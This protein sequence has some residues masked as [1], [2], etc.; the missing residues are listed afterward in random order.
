MFHLYDIQK[1]KTN[2]GKTKKVIFEFGTIVTF[3]QRA[4]MVV[5]REIGVGNILF[6]F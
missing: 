1:L 5:G 2:K 4:E 3:I 6:F